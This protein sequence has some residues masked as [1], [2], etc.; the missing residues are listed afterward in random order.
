MVSSC[1]LLLICPLA[2]TDVFNFILDACIVAELL[3]Y[4]HFLSKHHGKVI[5]HTLESIK[6]GDIV[7]ALVLRGKTGVFVAQPIKTVKP[8]CTE[9]DDFKILRDCKLKVILMRGQIA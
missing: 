6:P 8:L 1:V 7:Y 4:E 9:A 3:P 5:R 2:C